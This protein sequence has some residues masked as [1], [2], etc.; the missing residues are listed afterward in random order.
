MSL[1]PELEA[2]RVAIEGYAR[3]FGLDFFETRFEMVDWDDMNAIAAYGGFPTRYP[4]WR[5]GMAYEGLSKGYSYGLQ[6]I[7]ELVINND[8]CYA[9]LM[10][11]NDHV[12]QKLVIAH[13]YG[14]C[15]F[16][17]NNAAFAHTSRNMIDQ[18]A[19]HASRVRR[20]IDRYGHEKVET[21]ID[22]CLS[23]ENLIDPYLP[24]K[25]PPPSDK[26][27]K[28]DE[29]THID[30]KRFTA[31]DYMDA[32]INPPSAIE[33]QRQQ[34]ISKRKE[35]LRF[36]DEPRKD[37]LL[38]LLEHAPLRRWQRDVL[39]IIRDEAYYFAPQAMTKIM[40]EG[41]ASYWH[42]KIMTTRSA[43]TSEIVDFCHLHA[44][45][46]ATAP[47]QIN[48]Y[49][50]GLELWRDIEERWNTGRHGR[51]WEE[52]DDLERKANWDTGAMAGRDKIFQVRRIYNDLGF[53]NEFL[54]PEFCARQKLFTF[55]YVKSSEDYR[56]ASRE[57]TAVKQQMLDSL[58]NMGQPYIEVL[59]G[60][61]KNRG[62]LLLRH[63]FTGQTLDIGWTEQT[64]RNLQTLWGRP[65]AIASKTDEGE[66]VE[67]KISGNEFTVEGPESKRA[68]AKAS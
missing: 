10:T 52:C 36:P 41:W 13:V 35:A 33:K 63:D 12:S 66:A 51:E 49:K 37:V 61:H 2:E 21:F 54:T 39:S 32:F 4:H 9:Y 25:A 30:I 59:D 8:P 23:L 68:P 5:F 15:D 22:A 46:M 58:T 26:L 20:Y 38:F 18:M 27:V 42:S 47:N 44:G 31:K 43:T 65:V 45:T 6:K 24:F 7:Y 17:K 62:E 56:I 57:F 34:A 64:L 14:H 55:R 28:E 60:N 40:N 19:N 11:S 1:T 53:I 3:E 16:F 50:L 67:Y 48:P 29:T